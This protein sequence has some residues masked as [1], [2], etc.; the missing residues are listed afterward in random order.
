G[1]TITDP[2]ESPVAFHTGAGSV[3]RSGRSSLSVGHGGGQQLSCRCFRCDTAHWTQPRAQDSQKQPRSAK[4]LCGA[5]SRKVDV[6]IHRSPIGCLVS[7]LGIVSVV[8]DRPRPDWIAARE[9]FRN[10]GTIRCHP[11]ILAKPIQE[12]LI[13]RRVRKT[14]ISLQG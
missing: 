10:L 5:L 13:S 1:V 7:T 12:T 8:R 6:T 3:E 14:L 2:G 9:P 4:R 11:T